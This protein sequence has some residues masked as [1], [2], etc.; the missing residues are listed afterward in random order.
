MKYL[1]KFNEDNLP[2]K[3]LSNDRVTEIIANLDTMSTDIN[4]E[5]GKCKIISK[6]LSNYT[7]KSDKSNTQIDDAYVNFESLEG[8]FL[9]IINIISNIKSKLTSYSEEGESSIY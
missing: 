9:E 7:S 2:D 6:E 1:H 3:K 5:V 8:K 4:N